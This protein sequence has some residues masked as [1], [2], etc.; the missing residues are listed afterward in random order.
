MGCDQAGV[1]ASADQVCGI[2]IEEG[3]VIESEQ[4]HEI[5]KTHPSPDLPTQSEIDDHNIDHIPYR[6]WCRACVEGRGREQGHHSVDYTSRK[7]PTIGFDYL[8]LSRRGVFS[9]K[10]W[11]QESDEK[12]L[13]ILVVKDFKSKAV[14][15]HA[16]Q[17]KGVDDTRFAVDAL[18]SDIEW[19]GYS[20]IILWS[21]NEPAIKN[22]L[23]E[24]L[25]AL[26][27]QNMEQVCEEHPPQYDSQAN[28]AIE[29]GVQI[30]RG[31]MRTWQTSLE[32]RLGVHIPPTHPLMTWMVEHA[33]HCLTTRV[34]GRDG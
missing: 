10:D 6:S 31:M 2:G 5:A 12:Y 22:L 9:R 23:S 30:V 3:E 19:L 21:D 33:A 25:R 18:V 28:G 27:V 29:V 26:K 13:K 17:R 1:S 24:T 34:K 8:F 14:F 7:V 20:R 16:V 4:E 32:Q 15:A 11:V